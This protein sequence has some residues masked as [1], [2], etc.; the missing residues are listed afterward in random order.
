MYP[1]VHAAGKFFQI[2][3][4]YLLTHAGPK[5][6]ENSTKWSSGDVCNGVAMVTGMHMSCNAQLSLVNLHVPP[7]VI[8]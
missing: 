8:A 4:A 5:I 1:C 6:A 7:D 2:Q 3:K